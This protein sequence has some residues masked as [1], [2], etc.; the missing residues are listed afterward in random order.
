MKISVKVKPNNKQEKIKKISQDEFLTWIKSP[1]KEG[2]ANKAVIKVLA[3]YFS[4][5]KSNIVLI[6]GEKSKNKIFEIK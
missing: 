4:V 5:S 2:K 6:K 3:D 1:A